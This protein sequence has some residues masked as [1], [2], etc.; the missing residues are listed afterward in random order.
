MLILQHRS[1]NYFHIKSIYNY[2]YSIVIKENLSYKSFEQ[3]NVIL[4]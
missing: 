3:T 1:V 4:Q 2:Y